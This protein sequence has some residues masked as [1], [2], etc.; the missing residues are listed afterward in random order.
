MLEILCWKKLR[1]PSGDSRLS[2]SWTKFW[3]PVQMCHLN[4]KC[5]GTL[6][7]K[8]ALTHSYSSS[9]SC[10]LPQTLLASQV[11]KMKANH[12]RSFSLQTSFFPSFWSLFLHFSFIR[13][14]DQ[15]QPPQQRR[16][17]RADSKTFPVIYT[18]VWKIRKLVYSVRVSHGLV[19]LWTHWSQIVD[20]RVSSFTFGDIVPHLESKWRDHVFAP[21]DVTLVLEILVS[22]RDQPHLFSNG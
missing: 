11:L 8:S 7:C 9:R 21:L 2:T 20:A 13:I 6:K 18:S 17:S 1:K 14:L 5:C 12:L 3:D 10:P 19:A 4:K 16:Q 22:E 15:T